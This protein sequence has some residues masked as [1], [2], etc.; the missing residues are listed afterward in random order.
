MKISPWRMRKFMESYLISSHFDLITPDGIVRQIE[1]LDSRNAYALVQ[2]KNISEAFVGFDIDLDLVTFN[3]KSTL[4]QLGLD[5]RGTQYEIDPVHHQAQVK[6]HLH[7]ITPIAEKMLALL[8]KGARIGKLFAADPRRRVRNP[9]Y[10][11]RM[12]GR[13]DRRGRPLLSFGSTHARDDLLLA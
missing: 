6:V 12:F 7:A 11:M 5:G 13:V 8:N 4:A 9:D 10:L 3:L 2:I 1:R